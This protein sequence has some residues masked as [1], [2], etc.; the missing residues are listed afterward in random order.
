MKRD[1]LKE[2]DIEGETLEKIM[3]EHGKA[4]HAE[5][6]QKQ[7]LKDAVAEERRNWQRNTRRSYGFAGRDHPRVC[8]AYALAIVLHDKWGGPPP[9]VRGIPSF[10]R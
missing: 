7:E 3:A 2:L 1:F 4:K 5:H 10:M 6:L 9:R 8:E